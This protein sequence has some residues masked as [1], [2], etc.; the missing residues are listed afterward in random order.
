[1]HSL[2]KYIGGHGTTVGGMIVDSGRSPGPSTPT[3]SRCSASPKPAYHDLVYTE[4]LGAAA[5][6]GRCRTVALRNTG[7]ALSPF[8]A[9]LLMQGIETLPLRMERH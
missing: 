9:L 5:F 1:M 4:A 2:T 8:N 7:S 3:A 6:I